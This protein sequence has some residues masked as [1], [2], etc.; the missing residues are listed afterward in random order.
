VFQLPYQSARRPIEFL[1]KLQ[2]ALS[3]ERLEVDFPPK[4]ICTAQAAR[5]MF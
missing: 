2:K 4:S 1:L 3:E 5:T